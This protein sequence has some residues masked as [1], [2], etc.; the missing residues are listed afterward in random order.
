MRPLGSDTT[1]LIRLRA[2]ENEMLCRFGSSIGYCTI[3]QHP[4]ASV[5]IR[6]HT[7]AYSAEES[8]EENEMLCRFGSSVGHLCV[9]ISTFVLVKQVIWVPSCVS[10]GM[11][12]CA[13][14]DSAP[15]VSIRQ[16]ASAYVSI[17]Q[18]TSAYVSKHHACLAASA[19]VHALTAPAAPQVSMFALLY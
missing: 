13:C 18:H 2:E 1:V 11:G 3:R 5:G 15:Y 12:S 14:S 19:L 16:H 17:R 10:R 7:S 9:R 4:S 8:A 6:Q